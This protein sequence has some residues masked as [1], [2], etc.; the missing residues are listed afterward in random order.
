[1]LHATGPLAGCRIIH[2]YP[3]LYRLALPIWACQAPPAPIRSWGRR[4]SPGIRLIDLSIIIDNYSG[5]EKSKRLICF[6]PGNQNCFER[7]Q[8]HSYRTGRR[9]NSERPSGGVL[10]SRST[11]RPGLRGP[12]IASGE[13]VFPVSCLRKRGGAIF[14][15]LKRL[16]SLS[17][18]E[19]FPASGASRLRFLR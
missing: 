12:W 6:L 17:G 19:P 8:E 13:L 14:A 18:V 4:H 9:S 10:A 7:G 15:G 5:D 11:Y 1:M 3:T 2:L 16:N